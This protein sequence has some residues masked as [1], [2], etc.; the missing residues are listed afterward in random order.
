MFWAALRLSSLKLVLIW[1]KNK[2]SFTLRCI[3][4]LLVADSCLTCI[5]NPCM[6][7]ILIWEDAELFMLLNLV[8]V[9]ILPL[10]FPNNS[11]RT[12]KN[13]RLNRNQCKF[14]Q[15][16]QQLSN[17]KKVCQVLQVTCCFRFLKIRRACTLG[18]VRYRRIGSFHTLLIS[19]RLLL[20][21]VNSYMLWLKILLNLNCRWWKHQ[22]LFKKTW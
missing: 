18:T 8:S 5:K 2:P 15:T 3:N 9:N 16:F 1:T 21:N 19:S 6:S 17:W 22:L 13:W 20:R 12:K 11:V 4:T 14:F 10:T 7:S